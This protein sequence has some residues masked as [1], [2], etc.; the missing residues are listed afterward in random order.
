MAANSKNYTLGKGKLYLAN[1]KPGTQIATEYRY[2]GNTPEF[3]FT[4]ESEKLDHFSSEGGLREK[5]MSVTLEVTRTLNVVTDAINGENLALFMMSDAGVET[6]TTVGSTVTDEP[7]NDVKIGYNYLLGVTESN[8][9]GVAGINPVGFVVKNDASTPVTYVAGTDYLL[10]PLSGTFTVLGGGAIAAGT[11]LRV[12]YTTQNRSR[13]QIKSGNKSVE[14]AMRF[15]TDNPVGEN[16]IYTF[17]YVSISPN[18][19][20]GLISEEWMQISLMGEILKKAGAEA[21]YRNGVP[22][23]P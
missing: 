6:I 17:P 12:T 5:D 21:I 8:P 9:V 19:D 1:F 13:E 7:F 4:I 22:Y 16:S 15:E 14:G 2:I 3:T 20:L 23:T 11:N 10:N 18:G